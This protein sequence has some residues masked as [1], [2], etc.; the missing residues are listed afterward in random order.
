M[1]C[2]ILLWS[3]FVWVQFNNWPH[4]HVKDFNIKSIIVLSTEDSKSGLF[5]CNYVFGET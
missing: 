4:D 3:V 2:C 5:T 1:Q